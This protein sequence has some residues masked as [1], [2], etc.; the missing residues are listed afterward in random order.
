VPQTMLIEAPQGTTITD[1]VNAAGG[2]TAESDA[3]LLGGYF[4]SWVAASTAWSL[5]IDADGLRANGYSLGC[6]VIAVLPAGRCGV[7]ETA[8]ILAYLAH[9]SARQCGPCTFGLRA[10]AAAAGRVAGLT[11]TDGDLDHIK[12]WA[13]LLAGRGACRHPDGA[14]GLLGSA[15]RVFADEFER[16]DREHRC[17]AQATRSLAS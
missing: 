4:G 17:S 5:V 9:E 14:A 13:G 7:V 2:L 15:L 11:A 3:V 10:I 6:G 8:R 1:A 16:H 12:R